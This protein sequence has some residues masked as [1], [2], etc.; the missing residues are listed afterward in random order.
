MQITWNARP[1]SCMAAMWSTSTS[2]ETGPRGE[3]TFEGGMPI[4]LYLSNHMVETILPGVEADPAENRALARTSEAARA[5]SSS[6]TFAATRES[7]SKGWPSKHG[8]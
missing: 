1:P 4:V 5:G 7:Y 8:L 6:A 3:L 2:T